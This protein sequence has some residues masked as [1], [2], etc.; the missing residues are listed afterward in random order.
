M[1]VTLA[2]RQPFNPA[3]RGYQPVYRR[4]E[5]NHCPGCSRTGWYVGRI[6]AECAFCKTAI[7]LEDSQRSE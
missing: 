3:L 2:V 4:N 1:Q 7:P 6:T 5:V